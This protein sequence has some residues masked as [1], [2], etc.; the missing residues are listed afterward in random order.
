M[1]KTPPVEDIVEGPLHILL[2]DDEPIVRS[3]IGDYLRESGHDVEEAVDGL[4]AL[5]KIES[6]DFD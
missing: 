3:T 4:A 5:K 2:A 6:D 1:N